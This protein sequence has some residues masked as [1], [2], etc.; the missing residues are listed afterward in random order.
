MTTG[1]YRLLTGLPREYLTGRPRPLADPQGDF[2]PRLLH[3]RSGTAALQKRNGYFRTAEAVSGSSA[4]CDAGDGLAPLA[5]GELGSTIV[6]EQTWA[7][8]SASVRAHLPLP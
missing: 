7:A 6:R 5:D 1:Q 3:G 2:R 8:V 4:M